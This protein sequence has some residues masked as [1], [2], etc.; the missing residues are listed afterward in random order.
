M[1]PMLRERARALTSVAARIGKGFL[2][3]VQ[4]RP[5][6]IDENERLD[7]PCDV[8]DP[9]IGMSTCTIL[10]M[11]AHSQA[12]ANDGT[13]KEELANADVVS[14]S[15]LHCCDVSPSVPDLK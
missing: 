15:D 5:R 12:S 10:A 4:T 2:L 11:R 7:R 14:S 8:A 1:S 9:L 3:A 6:A 13:L